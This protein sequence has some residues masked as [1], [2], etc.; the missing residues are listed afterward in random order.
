MA[1]RTENRSVRTTA[2]RT[3]IEGTSARVLHTVTPQRQDQN[4]GPQEVHRRKRRQESGTLSIPYCI[5][6][7]VACVLTLIMGS[8]YLQ[9]QALSTSSQKKI[10]SLES[11]LAELKKVNADDLNRI[12]TSVNL[13]EIRDIAMNE[14]GMVYAT[15]ENVVLYK[16]TSQNYVSQYEDVPQEA[17][18]LVKSIIKSK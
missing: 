7:T 18:S 14:L 8:Y 15:Q 12:E 17:E 4:S 10:A 16:N 6:L 5:F 1:R 2:Y 11:E 3:E 13:E 9:Q